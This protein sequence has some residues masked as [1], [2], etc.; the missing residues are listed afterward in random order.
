M[1]KNQRDAKIQRE[2]GTDGQP[3]RQKEA[4]IQIDRGR[5]DRQKCQ[6]REKEGEGDKDMGVEVQRLRE[7][8]MQGTHKEACRGEDN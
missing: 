7:R 3:K 6:E 5:G 4:E 1:T 2:V 8:T